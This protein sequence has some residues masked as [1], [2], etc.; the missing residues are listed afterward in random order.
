MPNCVLPP[1]LPLLSGR[2]TAARTC[3][4]DV[5]LYSEVLAKGDPWMGWLFPVNALRSRARATAGAFPRFGHH[6]VLCRVR[7]DGRLMTGALWRRRQESCVRLMCLFRLKQHL[8]VVPPKCAVH[9]LWWPHTEGLQKK[10]PS[11]IQSNRFSNIA[12]GLCC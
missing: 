8:I 6:M 9:W 7:G 2:A 12:C 1:L 11:Q 4:L 3:S 10:T 5:A